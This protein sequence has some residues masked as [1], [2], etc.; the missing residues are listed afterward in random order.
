MEKLCRICGL[1][2][3]VENFPIDDLMKSG[4]RNECKKCSNIIYNNKE[5]RRELNLEKIII[6]DGVK[7]CRVCNIEQDINNFHL[8]RGTPDGHRHE[9]KE[10]VK[11]IQKKYK[12]APDF[13]KNR[14]EYDKKR[15]KKIKSDP[16]LMI[17]IKESD[18]KSYQKNR[19]EILKRRNSPEKKEKR[20][21]Y[22]KKYVKEHKEESKKYRENNK[23]LWREIS[24]RYR[25]K[26]PHIVVWRSILYSTLKRL[27]TMKE[28]HTIEMLGY[29][30]KELKSHIEKQFTTG[31]SWDNH[32]EWH[33]DHKR[34]VVDF[35]P[36]TS[37]KIVCELS[38]L[39]PMWGT[40][41]EIDGIIY[42][43]NINKGSRSDYRNLQI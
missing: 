33:I 1:L 37:V 16:E 26:N 24:E 29:S 38:N 22:N 19:E 2:K 5:R 20:N 36:D 6:T 17:K 7:K 42:E 40:T 41:R 21:E 8:K 14:S 18:K 34:S 27:G 23:Q 4:Y 9:C 11:N 13:K 12:E 28:G 30:A 43:G 35:P 31:M 3:S 15:W 32:G 10:C 39:R 25:K